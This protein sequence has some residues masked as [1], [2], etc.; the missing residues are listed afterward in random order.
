VDGGVG[1]GVLLL[2]RQ[3]EDV[4]NQF[5]HLVGD[6]KHNGE[7]ITIDGGRRSHDLMRTAEE[8]TNDGE[9]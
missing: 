8:T 9:T 2:Q 7:E 5:G 1:N 3:E 6:E 4:R